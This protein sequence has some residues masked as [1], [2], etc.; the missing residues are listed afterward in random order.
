MKSGTSIGANYKE[1]QHATSHKHFITT[2]EI[3]QRE[4]AETEY[5]L[6]LIVE[7]EIVE[8]K[9]LKDLRSECSELKAILTASIRTAKKNQ[10]TSK[11]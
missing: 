4:A 2:M 3:A 5:W 6:E 7:A 10:E 9:V 1:A 8:A 11:D